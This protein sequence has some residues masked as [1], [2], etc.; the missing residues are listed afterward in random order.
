MMA[1]KVKLLKIDTREARAKLAARGQPYYVEVLS[2]LHLG[3][4]KGA[5]RGRW[6]TRRWLADHYE[7]ETLDGVADDREPA[8]GE[9]VLTFDQAKRKAL[10][11]A[12]EADREAKGHA[13]RRWEKAAPYTV[14]DAIEAY[15]RYLDRE[16]KSGHNSR[17]YANG[18]ILPK[19]GHVAI[20][21]LD[22]HILSNWLHDLAASPRRTRAPAGVLPPPATDEEK[23][24]RRSSANRVYT[25]LRGALNMAFNDGH[26][27]S[28]AAWRRVKP[29]EEAD[30]A[31]LRCLEP[32]EARAL[33]AATKEP[34]RS[35]VIAALHSGA[36]FGEIT[37][38]V[39]G[40]FEARS[41]TLLIRYSKAKKTRRVILTKEACAFFARLCAARAPDEL[42]LMKA[43][44]EAWKS[45]DQD[46]P[47]R[48]A[49]QLAGLAPAGVHALRH[50]YA[51]KAL[52]DDVPPMVVARNLGHGD[53]SMLEKHYAHIS[54]KHSHKAIQGIKPLGLDDDGGAR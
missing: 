29:L 22:R 24:R 12:G 49:C 8:D 10:E 3:Y 41:D 25:V 54:D 5:K 36:R 35:L 28:D 21:D 18:S 27:D 7:V 32:E 14:A 2:G 31:R 53:L 43:N 23:R 13:Q 50:S 47:M 9:A 20:R 11:L 6:V 1:G 4:R 39:V 42:M 19:L 37:R 51:T 15:L 30:A 16:T 52:E 33:V 45:G 48:K 46:R 44:G 40:D 34:F 26:V 17:V 38:L